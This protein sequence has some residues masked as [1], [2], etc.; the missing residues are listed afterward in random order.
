MFKVWIFILY[1]WTLCVST[2]P[3]YW[4][5]L[6]LCYNIMVSLKYHV[7]TININ[8]NIV[9]INYC[10]MCK[11]TSYINIRYHQLVQQYLKWQYKCNISVHLDKV[12][13]LCCISP[14]Q[15]IQKTWHSAVKSNVYCFLRSTMIKNFSKG[16][17]IF[18]VKLTW[19]TLPWMY[20]RTSIL[21]KTFHIVS[22]FPFLLKI[23][24]E[25]RVK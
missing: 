5:T 18:S 17:W 20:I 21:T 14:L 6:L 22:A 2:V 19:W 3:W 12:L 7:N 4:D 8:V 25:Y 10:G 23:Y 11:N 24:I 1:L 15:Y 9:V 16:S 13:F